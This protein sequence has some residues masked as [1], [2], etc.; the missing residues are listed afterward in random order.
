MISSLRTIAIA[1]PAALFAAASVCAAEPAPIPAKVDFNRDIRQILSDNCFA[2]HGPD[3]AAREAD[4][5]LDLRSGATADLGGYAAIVPGKPA[6]SEL[7]RRITAKNPDDRMPPVD[8]IKKLTPRQ[9]ELLTAWVEQGGEYEGHWAYVPPRKHELPQ[10]KHKDWPRNG[11]DRFVLARLEA[12]GFAPSPEA[13][14]RTLIRRLSFDLT[15][16]P[17]TAAEVE[18]FVNDTHPKAYER[19]VERLLASPA[20]GE[21]MAAWWLDLVRYADT[22]GY[23]GDQDVSIWP[24]REYVIEAFNGNMPFDR[25][26]IEQLAGDLLPDPTT[27]QK[28]ASGYNRLGMMTAEGGAQ[29][30]EYLVKYAG[31]RVRNASSVWMGATLGCAECHDHKF[32][33]FTARDFYSFAAFFADL[34]EKGFYGGANVTG[35]WGPRMWLPTPQQAE[36]M[37]TLEKGIAEIEAE[38]KAAIPDLADRTKEWEKKLKKEDRKD[39]PQ[40][41]AAAPAKRVNQRLDSDVH[42]LQAYVV[43]QEKPELKERAEELAAM[44]AELEGL[45]KMVPTTL[46]SKATQPRV[47]RIL[48]RGNWMDES[49]PIVQ[50]AVPAFMGGPQPEEGERLTRL[51]LAKWLVDRDNPLTARTLVNRLWANCMGTGICKDL[52]DLGA[53]SEWPSH[54][55]LLDYLALHMIDSGWDIKDTLRL[56]V[57][58][59]TYRQASLPRTQMAEIDPYNRLLGRQ[60][61]WR[62]DAEMVRDNALDV[63]GLLVRRMGGESSKPYQPAGYY[64]QLNFPKREYKADEGEGLYRR[65]LYTHWQRSFLH[66]MLLAF[67]APTREECTAERPRSNTPLQSLV[68]LN[69]PSFVEAA[70]VFAGRIMREGGDTVEA[71]IAWAYRHALH[72]EPSAAEAA[73][74]AKLH[75]RHHQWY[76]REVTD[77]KE[78]LEVGDM[79]V[80]DSLNQAEFAAWASVARTLFNLHEFITRN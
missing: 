79:P 10:V 42:Q 48:P 18:A 37:A 24:Y 2:C 61:R 67:D 1:L 73:L 4:L 23:H 14:R 34:E 60:S 59:A 51:D 69:D 8:S 74:I 7:V 20:Y 70:R 3:E 75:Q 78:L 31:D 54:P 52:D 29:D 25:F 36:R 76:S 21:R 13:D 6:D 77:A 63:S 41:V 57:T 56:I 16:L 46:V 80:D 35:E 19:L 49:G 44:S 62:F 9:I 72:R 39:L 12:A 11:I 45:R 66:P 71:R 32:D 43:G 26:T 58:S 50:P 28:I 55:M 38:L 65:G 64:D 53:Q 40:A 33:P 5:R 68:L 15:G 17:P 22:V 30:K 27:Q 47:T